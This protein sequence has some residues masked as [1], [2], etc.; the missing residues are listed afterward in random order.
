MTVIQG[1]LRSERVNFKVKFLRIIF[2]TNRPTNINKNRNLLIIYPTSFKA[3][4]TGESIYGI[5]LV[6]Q[7][8]L[9]D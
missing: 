8:L 2:V 3:V 6:I 7:E 5:I 9:Q 1:D 4:L